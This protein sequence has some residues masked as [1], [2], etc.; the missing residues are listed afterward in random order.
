[1]ATARCRIVAT[2]AAA[3]ILSRTVEARARDAWLAWRRIFPPARMT[4]PQTVMYRRRC[5]SSTN[6]ARSELFP[7]VERRPGACER[8]PVALSVSRSLISSPRLPASSASARGQSH[9]CDGGQLR[10]QRRRVERGNEKYSCRH[11]EV[12]HQ[13][14]GTVSPFMKSPR[15]ITVDCVQR[16]VSFICG[17]ENDPLTGGSRFVGVE[18]I[19]RPSPPC[20][21]VA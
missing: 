15:S 21:A 5:R 8:E 19:R 11:D 18:R 3:F 17:H 13:S 2:P 9:G 16:Q 4:A 7:S 12:I 10:H 1:M 6:V 14:T 20:L